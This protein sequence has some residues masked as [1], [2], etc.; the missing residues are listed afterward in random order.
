[1]QLASNGGARSASTQDYRVA[2]VKVGS[3]HGAPRVWLEGR[4]LERAG[5]T[6]GTHY[7]LVVGDA[8]VTLRIADNGARIVSTKRRK[9]T[10][11]PV[12]DLNSREALGVFDGLDRLRVVIRDNEIHLLPLA[13]RAKANERLARIQRKAETGEPLTVGSLCHGGG[14]L[15]LALHEGMKAAGVDSTLRFANDIEESVLEQAQAH[16]PAWTPE[17]GLIAAPMQEIVADDWMMK[18][19]GHVDLL[20]AG[21]PCVAASLAGRAKKG[22]NMAEADPDAGHLVVA[23][24]GIVEALQPAIIVV[25]N[26]PPYQNT[27]S[28]HLIRHTLR[29]WGYQVTESILSGADFNA[30]EDRKRMAMV[31]VTAGLSFDMNAIEKPA[32]VEHSLGEMLEAVPLDA[33]CWS[34]MDYLRDKE[35]RD[36]AAGKGFRMQIVGPESTSVGTIGRDYQKNR[37]TEPK[38]RH[39]EKGDALLRLLTPTEHARIKG[40]PE[41]LIE[42][43][44]ATR[45]HALLG[46]GIVFAPFVELGRAIATMVRTCTAAPLAQAA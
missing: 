34:D 35:E 23:F 17:T 45:A 38:V 25:E 7:D 37:S 6:T 28:A 16:N 32:R 42:D 20:E 31:A 13:T 22:L 18:Q 43:M 9:D 10:D 30:L 12:I 14:V 36:K 8:R 29:D 3:N 41:R 44:P 11:L 40:V 19:L 26:V 1:M 46:N 2:D 4:R 24:L 39:P 33:E 27:A 15:S 5:F 21:I